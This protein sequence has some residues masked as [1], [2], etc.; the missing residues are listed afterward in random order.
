MGFFRWL[1][2]K[3]LG[4]AF[5]HDQERGEFSG[6]ILA[7]LAALFPAMPASKICARPRIEARWRLLVRTMQNGP[8]GHLFWTEPWVLSLL[9][10]VFEEVYEGYPRDERYPDL[11]NESYAGGLPMVSLAMPAE[12]RVSVWLDRAPVASGP[13][14]MP[15]IARYLSG[16]YAELVEGRAY[17]DLLRLDIST[18]P[19]RGQARRLVIGQRDGEG[20]DAS[21]LILQYWV[22]DSGGIREDRRAVPRGSWGQEYLIENPMVLFTSDGRGVALAAKLGPNWSRF[23]QGRVSEAGTV[24]PESLVDQIIK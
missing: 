16:V 24:L 18:A 19:A 1:R 11:Y 20:L 23:K 17:S 7:A 10:P 14:I 12:G 9:K 3:I 13:V 5:Y 4:V 15:G 8:V 2:D 6:N 21:G 22:A